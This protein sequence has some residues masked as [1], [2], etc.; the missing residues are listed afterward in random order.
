MAAS[1]PSAKHWCLTLNNPQIS[2][3][4]F[5][6]LWDEWDCS[7]GV[8]QLEAGEGVNRVNQFLPSTLDPPSKI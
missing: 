6:A 7:Y 1:T 2:L 5:R 4:D 3:A 8:A